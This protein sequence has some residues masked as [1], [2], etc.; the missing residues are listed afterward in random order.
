MVKQSA[1]QAFMEDTDMDINTLPPDLFDEDFDD[2]EREEDLE[3]DF[4]DFIDNDWSWL[5]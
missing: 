2:L 5:M 4:P 3:E 1:F